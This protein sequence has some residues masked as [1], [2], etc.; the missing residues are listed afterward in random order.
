M[1]FFMYLIYEYLRVNVCNFNKFFYEQV[2]YITILVM[3]V[4]F[5]IPSTLN[6][7]EERKRE[8]T[9]LSKLFKSNVNKFNI[10]E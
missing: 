3:F 5:V 10:S 9:E 7:L 6:Y 8:N 4:I 1:D 2:G